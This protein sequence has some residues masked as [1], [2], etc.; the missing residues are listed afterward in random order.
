MLIANLQCFIDDL[1][2]LLQTFNA[3]LTIC[4]ASLQ[5]FNA[6]L[7][8]CNASLQFFNGELQAYKGFNSQK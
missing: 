3:S 6:P 7:T 5:T 4:N 2:S 8:I 1:Q